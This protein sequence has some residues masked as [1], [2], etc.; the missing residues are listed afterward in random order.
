MRHLAIAESILKEHE[1]FRS[2]AYQCT[3]GKTTVG[4]GRNLDDKGV[5][6]EEALYLL[7]NDILECEADLAS[8]PYW[9][10]LN[11]TQKAALI[12]MRFCLGPSG[13]RQFKKMEAALIA[14]DYK[15]AAAQVLDSRFATQ[16]K[17]R[18]RDI[19]DMLVMDGE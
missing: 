8:M 12:D 10:A 14:K 18:A 6:V 11:D 16:V 17:G 3:E 1:G 9:E 13:Y 7:A 2:K 4:Y 19:A 15:E 5:S